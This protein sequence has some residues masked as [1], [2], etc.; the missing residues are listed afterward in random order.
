M[1]Y[2]VPL[3][4]FQDDISGNWLKQWNKHYSCY[5]SNGTIPHQK[6][7]SEFY[8]RFVA[9]SPF[10]SPLEIMQGI[11]HLIETTFTSPIVAWDCQEGEEVGGS[12]KHK[13]SDEGFSELFKPVVSTTLTEAVHSS[14]TKDVPTQP[15]IDN[16]NN[17]ECAASTPN[18]AL[19][20]ELSTCV[21]IHKDTLTE[22]LHTILLGVA[23]LNSIVTDGLNVPKLQADYMCQYKG[24]LIGKH[25]KMISQVMAFAVYDIVP[26]EVLKAWLIIGQLTVLLWHTEIKD[27]KL[28][29]TIN[30][31][32][33]LDLC[34]N[35]FLNITCKC[36]PSILITKPK[37][38]FLVHLSFYIC[39]FCPALLLS[40]EHYEAYNAIFCA[41]SIF[42]NRL[43]PSRNITWPF[44][45]INHMCCCYIIGRGTQVWV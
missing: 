23:W 28:C 21:D 44:I 13:Q 14:G 10:A 27:I 8:V 15:V 24:G 41:A 20:I 22:I 26:K 31:Q 9:T 12:Q 32:K 30:L 40:T 6:L 4:I 17:P 5:L 43:A 29:T 38:H 34:I 2:S 7:K 37:F 1:V 18:K 39:C 16:L 45:G 36:S 33:E 19:A 42:S 11:Q 25:F 35:D 3:V